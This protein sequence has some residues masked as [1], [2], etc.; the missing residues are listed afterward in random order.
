MKEDGMQSL[1]KASFL[2]LVL[3]LVSAKSFAFTLDC[4]ITRGVAVGVKSISLSEE[5]LYINGEIEI[6]LEKSRVNCGHFKKQM[7]FDGNALGY[8]I[9]LKSCT[10]DA[11]LKGDVIDSVR[12]TVAEVLCE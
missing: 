1:L 9:I 2:L 6:P 4:K 7:R 10:S 5:N 3:S 12:Q 8:Q 11:V